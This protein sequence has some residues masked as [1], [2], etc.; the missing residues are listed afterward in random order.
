M[1]HIY[2]KKLAQ[3]NHIREEDQERPL[4]IAMKKAERL[5]Q[6]I[7]ERRELIERLREDYLRTLKTNDHAK[8]DKLKL[9]IETQIIP[10]EPEFKLQEKV[11][12][13][14]LI[15]SNE[16]TCVICLT[17][18]AHLY[19]TACRHLI[20]CKD[21][22]F[23]IRLQQKCPLCRKVS[24]YADLKTIKKKRRPSVVKK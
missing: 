11:L 5:M 16:G 12:E 22:E 18:E 17:S 8:Q 20:S 13:H 23:I 1:Q 3:H 10:A 14:N 15:D 6:V 9:I 7:P 19:M 21:C 4:R 2:D 24:G